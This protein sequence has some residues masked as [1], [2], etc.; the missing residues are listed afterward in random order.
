MYPST[1]IAALLIAPTV[2]L[3]HITPQQEACF[4]RGEIA[5]IVFTGAQLGLDKT[6]FI[7]EA[8]TV[9]KRERG[10]IQDIIEMAYAQDRLVN[11]DQQ[12]V[13]FTRYIIRSCFDEAG[14]EFDPLEWKGQDDD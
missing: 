9:P 11:F 14:I 13:W 5:E 10:I 6:D 7:A 1:I 8:L 3:A 4:N 2:A 12:R